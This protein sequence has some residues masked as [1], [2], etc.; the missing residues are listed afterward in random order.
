MLTMKLLNFKRFSSCLFNCKKNVFKKKEK[1][2][3]NFLLELVVL[4]ITTK[5]VNMGYKCK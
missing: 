1:K 2:M 5:H 4:F 3:P